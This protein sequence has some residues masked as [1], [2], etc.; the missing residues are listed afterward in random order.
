[1]KNIINT[2]DG[3]FELKRMAKVN[4]FKTHVFIEHSFRFDLNLDGV[5]R[6]SD[7]GYRFMSCT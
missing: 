3:F 5:L 1:M 6:N 2:S 4:K 7:R